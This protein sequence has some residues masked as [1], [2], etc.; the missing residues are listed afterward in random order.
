MS[1]FLDELDELVTSTL[2]EGEMT[3]EAIIADL[4]MK[5]AALKGEGA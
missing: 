1:V 2:E 5:I 4:E 3:L